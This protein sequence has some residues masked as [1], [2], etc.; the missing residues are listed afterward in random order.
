M[1]KLVFTLLM[2]LTLSL[3]AQNDIVKF[4]GI[5]IDGNK[6]EM[7]SKLEKK[8]FVLVNGY[9]DMLEGSF[10]GSNVYVSIVTYN[11][12]VYR[13][14]VQDT[15]GYNE[16]EIKIR[17]NNLVYQF[18]TNNKYWHKPDVNQF[19]GEDFSISYEMD[20]LHKQIQ[21]AYIQK[22]EVKDDE[23]IRVSNIVWFTIQKND[24]NNYSIGLYYDNLNNAPNGEDL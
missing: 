8:G 1:R 21:A 19:L 23:V 15:I 14:F 7:I 17:F 22:T 10:N 6:S 20:V 4:L 9:D 13:I 24:I 5:P 12:K 2:F 11:N 18:Q 16:A 3:N